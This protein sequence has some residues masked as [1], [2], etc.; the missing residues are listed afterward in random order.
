M[1]VEVDGQTAHAATGGN[2]LADS[3]PVVILIHGAGMDAT[4][5]SLQTRYLSYRDIRA[6]AVDLPGHGRSAG[7][8]LTSVGDM[9]DWLGHFCDA[10]GF[11]VVH[12]AGHSMGT[13]IAL[14][15]AA[16]RPELVGSIVL[17]GTANAMP[18]HPDLLDKAAND[19][20]AAGAL[21]AAWGHSKSAHVGLN[22]TPG[23]WMTSGTQALVERSSPGVLSTDF[24]ACMAYEDALET[25]GEV[26]CPATVIIGHD[27]KMTPRKAG[28]K[29]AE[30]LPNV[31]VIDLPG[32]GH[33]MMSEDPRTIR[34]AIAQTTR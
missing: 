30:A 11:D 17:M 2:G 29:V 20:P 5:W 33:Q 4:V 28:A 22:P 24:A 14:E 12:L 31:T 26:T 1:I 3:G 21:M 10:A 18:V 23:L 9:A 8:A 19:L 7:E 25:A 32:V 27:D 15:L 13:F 16:R 6:V 34:Q